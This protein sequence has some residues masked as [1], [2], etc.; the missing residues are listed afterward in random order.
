MFQW[1]SSTSCYLKPGSRSWMI[2]HH[3]AI[4]IN[5]PNF[6]SLGV[7]YQINE[8]GRTVVNG[9]SQIMKTRTLKV[10]SL[11]LF[12]SLTTPENAI[13]ILLNEGGE[14]YGIRLMDSRVLRL[15]SI[16]YFCIYKQYGQNIGL[17]DME[18]TIRPRRH[19]YFFEDTAVTVYGCWSM[20]RPSMIC[21]ADLKESL[22]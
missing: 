1:S 8:G 11:A 15:Q 9:K 16:N 2:Q 6:E 22:A 12:L 19:I 13:Q 17:T 3:G 4:R 18:E 20:A 5:V 10:T 14:W 7:Y 21:E